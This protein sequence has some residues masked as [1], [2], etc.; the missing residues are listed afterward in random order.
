MIEVES[1]RDTAL[2]FTL[3]CG[4]HNSKRPIIHR[5]AY[6]QQTDFHQRKAHIVLRKL[7]I[8]LKFISMIFDE[9]GVCLSTIELVTT[10]GCI[11]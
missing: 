1:W 11:G 2:S 9:V 8:L 10:H 4:T 7:N 6:S 3:R 5:Q